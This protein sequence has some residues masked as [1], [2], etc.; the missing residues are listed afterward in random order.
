MPTKK[1]SRKKLLKEPDEFI[2][3]TAKVLQFL[4]EN[5]QKV[6]LYAVV[7]VV[8]AAVGSGGYAYLRWQQGNEVL[9]VVGL[10]NQEKVEVK[11]DKSSKFYGKA[12]FGTF[13]IESKDLKSISFQP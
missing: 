13:Q 1:V 11:V 6:T 10:R 9:F 7:A 4:R 12:D 8:V 5:R 2:S 3:T